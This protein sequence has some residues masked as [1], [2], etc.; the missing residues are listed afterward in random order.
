MVEAVNGTL[1]IY[2]NVTN[3]GV[4]DAT[5][6]TLVLGGNAVT[7]AGSLSA[8]AG[9]IALQGTTIHGGALT[10]AG[11]FDVGGGAFDLD[12]AVLDGSTSML[13]NFSIIDMQTAFGLETRTLTLEGTIK[14]TGR[15]ELGPSGTGG[16][17]TF[18]GPIPIGS[19]LVI[20]ATGKSTQVTLKGG[21]TI[22]LE[23]YGDDYIIGD[24]GL[25][26]GV[27]TT[28]DNVN[29]TIIGVGR[30]GDDGL[31]LKNSGFIDADTAGTSASPLVIDTGTRTVTNT[32]TLTAFDEST[33][34]I[35]SP[36][37]NTGGRLEETRSG[38]LIAEQ[39]AI[40]GTAT[41]FEGGTIEFGG[42]TKTAVQFASSASFGAGALVLDDSIHFK[43][44]ISGFAKA[45][46]NDEIDL[47]DIN[48][49][50]AQ[51][52]SYSGGILT[53]KDGQGH[54]AQ[55]H[56]SGTY[57]L[58]NFDLNDDGHGGTLLTDPPV[59]P[60]ANAALF[61]SHIAAA[62]P[63]TASFQD[64]ALSLSHPAAVPPLAPPPHG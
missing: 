10:G 60:Q 33:L 21:G 8:A 55:L 35:D 11:E 54:T 56:F 26:G 46:I 2:S 27:P 45:N 43:G 9:V 20:G 64:V 6:G 18:A 41:L 28:L 40:G 51:K 14:N 17:G 42:P 50:T 24:A 63:L 4:L 29:D 49:A 52:V 36:L 39:G 3:A 7:N 32:G 44:V 53:I 1:S 58:A 19:D 23:A 15:I 31:T 38:D 30:I 62:F 13:T 48:S 61:G 37:N 47:N 12:G 34:Y 22:V 57:T 16:A 25:P 5:A 59:A